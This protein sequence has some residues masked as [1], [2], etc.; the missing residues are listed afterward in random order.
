M[1]TIVLLI[2]SSLFLSNVP[3]NKENDS[4]K[5]VMALKIEKTDK[6]KVEN[7]T[8]PRTPII[9]VKND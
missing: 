7:I 2:V 6:I 1:K 5:K 8:N 9:I 3:N 4:I